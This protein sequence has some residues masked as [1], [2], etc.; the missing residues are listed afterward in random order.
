MFLTVRGKK[1]VGSY[2]WAIIDVLCC[3]YAGCLL[4]YIQK[5]INNSHLPCPHP[6]FLFGKI[7]FKLEHL[8]CSNCCSLL[9]FPQFIPRL[10]LGTGLRESGD[11]LHL[12]FF[13]PLVWLLRASRSHA[14]YLSTLFLPMYCP[15]FHFKFFSAKKPLSCC[16]ARGWLAEQAEQQISDL[17]LSCT[18]YPEMLVSLFP[19]SRKMY[20]R[21]YPSY[22]RFKTL[23]WNFKGSVCLFKDSDACFIF[24][25][26]VYSE[27]E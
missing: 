18:S 26:R 4:C 11:G 6:L 1:P 23:L 14:M 16:L 27:Q 22:P 7:Q 19:I 15:S 25:S 17:L 10:V 9:P 20:F 13:C 5:D 12:P 8:P 2:S 21:S 3:H 24:G